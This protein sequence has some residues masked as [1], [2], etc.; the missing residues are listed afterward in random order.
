MRKIVLGA[1]TSVALGFASACF[2]M[3]GMGGGGG[4]MGTGGYGGGGMRSSSFDDYATAV[5]LIHN[6][7]YAQA[8]PYLNR[9]LQQGPSAD[10]LNYLGYTHRMLGDYPASLDF[11]NRALARNPD[12]KGAHEYLGELY[13]KMNQ[14]ANANAQLA[15]LTRLCPDGCEEKEVLTKAISDYR[16]A[17]TAPATPVAQPVA[18]TAPAATAAPT[19]LQSG[20]ATQPATAAQPASSP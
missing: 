12:H 2:A 16:L 10:V 20:T 8:I 14:L 17:A 5:R 13:L 1:T 3:G 19:S 18:A 7:K 11:Y 4:G 6:E 15:E 9:A